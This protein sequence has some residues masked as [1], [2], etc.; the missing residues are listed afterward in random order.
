MCV[1]IKDW[2]FLCLGENHAGLGARH[3]RIFTGFTPEGGPVF[4]KEFRVTGALMALLRDALMPNL[5]QSVEGVPAFL[6]GGPFANIAHGCNSV[7]AT[8]MALA[9]ADF[10]VPE[11]G[12]ALYPGGA[13]FLPH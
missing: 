10:S 12:V 7:L 6:H 4:A 8:R 1:K 2:P 9:D 5:V 11:A 3:G 13:T